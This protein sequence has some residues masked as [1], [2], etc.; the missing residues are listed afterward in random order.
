MKN[1]RHIIATINN[2]LEVFRLAEA[3][4]RKRVELERLDL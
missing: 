2:L 4:Y 3:G 1:I